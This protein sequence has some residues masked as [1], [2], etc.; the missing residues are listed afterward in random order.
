MD[1]FS[2]QRSFNGVFVH[3]FTLMVLFKID[4]KRF[5]VLPL[6]G[7]TPGAVNMDTVAFWYPFKAVEVESRL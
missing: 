1:R 4:P 6:K 5:T 7:D 2:V 3:D